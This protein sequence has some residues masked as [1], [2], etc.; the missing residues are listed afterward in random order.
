MSRKSKSK[1]PRV[2]YAI[3]LGDKHVV[4][5]FYRGNGA[6]DAAFDACIGERVAHSTKAIFGGGKPYTWP[7]RASAEY[8]AEAIIG[9][10]VIEVLKPEWTR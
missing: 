9:A 8:I 3:A 4:E 1:E 7:N 2:E 10:H 5:F 6:R